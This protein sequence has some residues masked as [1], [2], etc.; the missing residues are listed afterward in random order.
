M[1]VNKE[2]VQRVLNS[3]D[4][5]FTKEIYLDIYENLNNGK[6]RFKVSRGC[7]TLFSK[8]YGPIV[9]SERL[10]VRRIGPK[11]D[12]N[13]GVVCTSTIPI[14]RKLTELKGYDS[15]AITRNNVNTELPK[16]RSTV[17]RQVEGKRKRK[18]RKKYFKFLSGP[19][20]FV[21]SACKRHENC[22]TTEFKEMKVRK[23]LRCD[24][25]VTIYYGNKKE[26]ICYICNIS[27]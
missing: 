8:L 21:N 9:D 24:D 4:G 6:N 2:G 10:S 20:A 26:C 22:F 5:V 27:K 17:Q 16:F 23:T 18:K 19:L 7:K 11:E 12:K 13:V 25:E 3:P 1:R 14:G 15:V